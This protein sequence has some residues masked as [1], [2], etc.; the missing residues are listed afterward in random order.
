M[1]T[2]G[3][4][5]NI[6]LILRAGALTSYEVSAS[7]RYTLGAAVTLYTWVLAVLEHSTRLATNRYHMSEMNDT[8][9]KSAYDNAHNK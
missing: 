3:S 1:G 2:C 7:V 5:F 4:D 9:T 8:Y 6:I